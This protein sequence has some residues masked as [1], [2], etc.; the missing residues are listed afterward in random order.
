MK[1]LLSKPED[2]SSKLRNPTEKPG[3]RAGKCDLMIGVGTGVSLGLGG[4]AWLLGW[5]HS[6]GRQSPAPHTVTDSVDTPWPGCGLCP[7]LS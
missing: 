4:Q 7:C 5:V 6:G 1:C 2:L 3:L